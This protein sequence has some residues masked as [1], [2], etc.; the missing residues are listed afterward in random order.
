MD[1]FRTHA[2]SVLRTWGFQVLQDD[3]PQD[4]S[5]PF[6]RGPSGVQGLIIGERRLQFDAARRKQGNLVFAILIPLGILL[7]LAAVV[8]VSFSDARFVYLVAGGGF[9][10]LGSLFLGQRRWSFDSEMLYVNYTVVPS[11]TPLPR[12]RPG[13]R[14]PA[15]EGGL[16]LDLT[17]SAGEVVTQNVSTKLGTSRQ[18][19]ASADG[20]PELRALPAQF[21]RLLEG[22]PGP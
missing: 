4:F 17:V 6:Y 22:P 18:L 13:E 15:T 7:I 9:S 5:G 12:V 19:K 11:E 2:A 8:G 3:P 14:P 20:P 21:V 10:I 16:R 1:P